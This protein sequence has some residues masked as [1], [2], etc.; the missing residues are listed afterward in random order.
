MEADGAHIDLSGFGIIDLLPD[1]FGALTLPELEAAEAAGGEVVR[2]GNLHRAG[3]G[4]HRG[5]NGT[6]VEAIVD[7]QIAGKRIVD[8]LL[9]LDGDDDAPAGHVPGPF[10]AM[11]ADIGA[12]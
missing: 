8:A 9:R 6:G 11:H 1:E 4:A 7:R 12:A 5:V 2:I 3:G 10:D